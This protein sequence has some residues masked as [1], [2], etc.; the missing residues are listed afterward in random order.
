MSASDD[1]ETECSLLLG[2]DEGTR[3]ACARGSGL[4]LLA[5]DASELFGIGKD[6]VHVLY[7]DQLEWTW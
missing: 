7:S 4:V 1:C 5:L 2:L 3:A 6:E